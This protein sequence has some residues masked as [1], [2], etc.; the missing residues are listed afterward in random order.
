MNTRHHFRF[1]QKTN[2][3]DKNSGFIVKALLIRLYHKFF[4]EVSKISFSSVVNINGPKMRLR[5][6]LNLFFLVFV[7]SQD[8]L[9]DFLS[10]NDLNVNLTDI[11]NEESR[12]LKNGIE[13]GDAWALKVNDASGKERSEFFWG[14]NY[15]LGS[16][17]ECE[18]MNEPHQAHIFNEEFDIMDWNSTKIKSEVEVQYR[19]I[20]LTHKSPYQFNIDAF[21]RSILHIGLCLPKS[22]QVSDVNILGKVFAKTSFNQK[23]YGEVEYVKTRTLNV[24]QGFTDN[25]FVRF[26]L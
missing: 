10:Y 20:Y 4:A 9:V 26:F 16:E 12:K 22:C 17:I 1:L 7:N 18:S 21:N 3:A 24:R 5:I 6:A 8:L 23:V 19:M 2:F 15:F 11:C 14:N 13:N 25:I